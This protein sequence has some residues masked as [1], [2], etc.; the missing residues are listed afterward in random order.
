MDTG[1]LQ[2]LDI[3]G[4]EIES[5]EGDED[6]EK[7]FEYDRVGD[8]ESRSFGRWVGGDRFE[9]GEGFRQVFGHAAPCVDER[10]PVRSLNRYVLIGGELGED[11]FH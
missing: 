7:R 2:S 3:L 4:H 8:W 6:V 5:L 9:D 10:S 11:A 1:R